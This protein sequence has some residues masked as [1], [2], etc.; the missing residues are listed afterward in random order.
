MGKLRIAYG[1]HTERA[2]RHKSV[3]MKITLMPFRTKEIVFDT[4]TGC[5]AIEVIDAKGQGDSIPMIA[6]LSGTV[7][8][9]RVCQ[10]RTGN[11]PLALA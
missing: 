4:L 9:E 5:Y 2:G 1:K 6:T 3:K 7:N 8:K 11:T 10:H